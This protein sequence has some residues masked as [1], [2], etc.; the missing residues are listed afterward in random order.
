MN[1][2]HI[3]EDLVKWDAIAMLPR[4][5]KIDGYYK[6]EGYPKPFN[7]K[8]ALKKAALVAFVAL[9]LL[10]IYHE[11]AVSAEMDKEIYGEY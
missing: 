4:K 9:G 7:W 3:T 10:A 2:L 5:D 8:A 6:P 11:R 1:N